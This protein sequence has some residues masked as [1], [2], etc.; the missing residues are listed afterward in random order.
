MT[1]MPY[2][3]SKLSARSSTCSRVW[4]PAPME[5]SPSSCAAAI[6]SSWS[7][8]R[9]SALCDDDSGALHPAM[10]ATSTAAAA[11]PAARGR[12]VVRDM[13]VSPQV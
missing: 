5:T 3:S 1:S 8:G 4:P 11:S 13:D 9:S 12:R 2:S 10:A 7:V 6:S